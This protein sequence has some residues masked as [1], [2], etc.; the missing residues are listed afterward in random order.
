ME[1]PRLGLVLIRTDW[2]GWGEPQDVTEE[3]ADDTG[4]MAGALARDFELHGPWIVDSAVTLEACKKALRETELD[5][6]VVAYQTWEEDR[7]LVNL[8]DAVGKRPLVVWCYLPRGASASRRSAQP[9]ESPYLLLNSGPV[10]TF[11][12][13]GT[14]NNLGVPFLFT[15][16][17]PNDPRLLH[18]LRVAV[19]AA[20]AKGML[21]EARIGLL[22]S[23]EHMMEC[24]VVDAARLR[25]DLGPVVENIPGEAYLNAL[26]TVT[27]ES[28]DGYLADLHARYPVKGVSDET[29]RSAAAAA[30]GLAQLANN[31][32]LDYV[33]ID[34]N[35][36]EV[37]S[38]AG[39][40]PS[41]YPGPLESGKALFQS[42]TDLGVATAS[43]V[44]HWLTGS[45]VLLAEIWFWD[46]PKNQ[47]TAGH[48]GL[49]NPEMGH[50][51]HVWVSPDLYFAP[52]PGSEGAQ[53]QFIARPGRVTLF[54][55]R[56]SPSGWKAIAT[57][58]MCLELRPWTETC[59]H[60][61]VR[62]DAQ[63]D[64]FLK[65]IARVGA[66]QHWALAY[67]SVLPE[68]EAFCQVANITLEIVV[69]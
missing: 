18:D 37:I 12:A 2:S 51:D 17:S 35:S 28:I 33:G 11:A 52:P 67:G 41:L 49:Q 54:Q 44:L 56:S 25:D 10:G 23:M 64:H 30:L 42:D 29:L 62:L 66:T 36:P 8:L 9:L 69:D 7:L 15:Y 24:T 53:N 22:P 68:I 4:E 21:R 58:G 48:H 27:Q 39:M 16:G 55:L 6:V 40:R 50:K 26:Q 60:A 45:P 1:N 34:D 43:L 31:F 5:L 14:L 38:A 3:I 19:R 63:I 59:P 65:R 32:N 46:G 57:S 47:V 13:L 61:V 20:R